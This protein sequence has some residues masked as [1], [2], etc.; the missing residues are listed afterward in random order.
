MP[1]VTT[2]TSR[3]KKRNITEKKTNLEVI[4]KGFLIWSWSTLSHLQF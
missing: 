4:H 3:K 1:L 2:L